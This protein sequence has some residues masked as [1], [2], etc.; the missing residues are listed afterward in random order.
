MS[1]ISGTPVPTFCIDLILKHNQTS[2]HLLGDHL[3][4]CE[5]ENFL[6]ERKDAHAEFE[7]ER[8]QLLARLHDLK[9]RLQEKE[10]ELQEIDRQVRDFL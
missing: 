5:R 2:T 10:R 3:P 9:E 6:A 7:T 1:N 8:A 4:S